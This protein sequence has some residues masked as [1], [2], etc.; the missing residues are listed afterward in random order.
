M[1]IRRTF[2]LLLRELR[3]AAGI[4]EV[5]TYATSSSQAGDL[6]KAAGHDDDRV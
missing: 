2:R 6:P 1:E 3:V 5:V 4:V